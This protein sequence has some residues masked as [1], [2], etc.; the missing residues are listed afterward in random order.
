MA[1]HPDL[2]LKSKTNAKTF[3]D[4]QEFGEATVCRLCNDIAEDAIQSKCRHIFDRECMKQYLDSSY[5]DSVSSCPSAFVYVL[6]NTTLAAG[7]SSLSC[8]LD[9]WPWGASFRT[10]GKCYRSARHSRPSQSW[11]MAVVYQNWSLSGG[12]VQPQDAGLIYQESRLQSICQL[13]R[14]DRFPTAKSGVQSMFF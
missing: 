12:A 13:P 11:Y 14:L 8:P 1:C 3:Q 9:D 10:W 4:N 5:R 2:V 6:L 7:V